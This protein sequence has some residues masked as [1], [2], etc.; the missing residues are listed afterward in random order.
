LYETDLVE[1]TNDDRAQFKPPKANLLYRLIG[2]LRITYLVITGFYEMKSMLQLGGRDSIGA[3]VKDQQ[4]RF[5]DSYA[6]SVEAD[7]LG[8]HPT[9]STLQLARKFL[10]LTKAWKRE[11]ESLGR[12]FTV[13]VLPRPIDTA[14]AARLFRDFDG[15]VIFSN[16]YFGDYAD[17]RF[18]A[19]GH[20]NEYGNLKI[21]EFIAD[22]DMFPFRGEFNAGFDAQ[23]L[24]AQVDAYYRKL[25]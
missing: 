10:L 15:R 13:L 18:R 5:H 3:N 1:L 16:P 24:E 21:A 8:E 17:F 12:T 2:R 9:T 25:Q 22:N 4:R 14:V 7:F 20:W 19:D 11:V 23:E 6:D